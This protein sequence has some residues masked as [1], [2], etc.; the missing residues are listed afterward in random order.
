MPPE[1]GLPPERDLLPVSGAQGGAEPQHD[2]VHG[3]HLG[4]GLTGADDGGGMPRPPPTPGGDNEERGDGRFLYAVVSGGHKPLARASRDAVLQHLAGDPRGEAL[5]VTLEDVGDGGDGQSPGLGDVSAAG[6]TAPP[7]ANAQAPVLR[8]PTWAETAGRGGLPKKVMH[9]WGALGEQ[10]AGGT[11]AFGRP[12]PQGAFSWC[13][14]GA[15]LPGSDCLPVDCSA[16]CS[17][18]LTSPAALSFFPALPCP[19]LPCPALPCPALPFPILPCPALLPCGADMKMDDD[20]Y[21]NTERLHVNF[22]RF[23]AGV[24]ACYGSRRYSAFAPVSGPGVRVRP[25][26]QPSV[27]PLVHRLAL[28]G[29]LSVQPGRCSPSCT[30]LQRW[31]AAKKRHRVALHPLAA[32]QC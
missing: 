32:P 11:V 2:E 23:D 20:T 7:T 5:L 27:Q 10:A 1:R 26:V 22:D 28:L 9:M 14:R 12:L 8:L 21:V 30:T 29:T 16:D 13:K 25:S 31:V 17:L 6:L 4:R 19:A 3:Q 15:V 24:P 18:P